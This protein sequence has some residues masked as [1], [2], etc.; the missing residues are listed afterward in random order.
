MPWPDG[1]RFSTYLP[2]PCVRGIPDDSLWLLYINLYI[3]MAPR[4]QNEQSRTRLS[5]CGDVYVGSDLRSQ[6]R[7]P[8]LSQLLS[9]QAQH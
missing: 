4:S 2:S 9:E 5:H 3:A 8:R 1:C 6:K 7:P